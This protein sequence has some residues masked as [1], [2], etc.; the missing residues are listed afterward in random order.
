LGPDVAL[1]ELIARAERVL[2]HISRVVAEWTVP[3]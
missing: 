3:R 2:G 1:D